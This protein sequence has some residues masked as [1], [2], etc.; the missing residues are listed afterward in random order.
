MTPMEMAKLAL[1]RAQI[2]LECIDNPEICAT[3]RARRIVRESTLRDVA[4][5]LEMIDKAG[6]GR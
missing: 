5:A 6:P 1:L 3:P 4:V 2:E